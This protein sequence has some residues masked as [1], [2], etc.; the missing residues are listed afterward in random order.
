MVRGA[1]HGRKG[2]K[3]E[4]VN[5]F[6]RKPPRGKTDPFSNIMGQRGVKMK[7][8]GNFWEGGE[9]NRFVHSNRF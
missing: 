1:E 8:K 5:A 6:W 4:F 7:G 9:N 3:E 2:K